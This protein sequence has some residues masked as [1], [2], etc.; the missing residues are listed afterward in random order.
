MPFILL[1]LIKLSVSLA[2]VFLFYYFI[3][4]KLTFYN[5]N[6]WYLLA[7]TVL[8][9]FIPF[10]NISPVLE[11]N[12]WANSDVVNWMP[13]IGTGGREVVQQVNL[14]SPWNILLIV[15]VSGMLIM[16]IR[17][18]IQLFSFRRMLRNAARIS[19][20]G[21]SL[22][23]VDANIIPFSF[24]NSIFINRHLHTET[25]LQ[26][27]ISHEF[28]HVK[29]R[30]S[31]DII[32]AEVLCLLN[33]YN[34]FVWLIRKCIRQNLEFIADGKVLENGVDRKQYQYLL[35]KVIGNNQFSIASKF[36]FS[37]LKKRIA[38]MN[39]IRSAK[40]NL[41]RF[42]FVLPLA[43]VLLLAFRN[44]YDKA[45]Q[46]APAV[47]ETVLQDTT[48]AGKKGVPKL[49][50][51]I[52]SISV[53]YG[54]ETVSADPKKQKL[55]E[56]VAVKR[57]DGEKEVYD[58]NSM[59][60]RKA[61]EKKYGVKLEDLVPPPPPT[62]PIPPAASDLSIAVIPDTPPTPTEAGITP[63]P[64]IPP[65]P[66]VQVKL[67]ES[68]KK[69][70]INNKKATVW[71]K[72]GQ[73]EDYDLNNPEQKAKFEIKYGEFVAPPPPPPAKT[74]LDREEPVAAGTTMAGSN[75]RTAIRYSDRSIGVT[76]ASPRAS[77]GPG[78]AT[79]PVATTIPDASAGPGAA[80]GT[81]TT[82]SPGAAAGPGEFVISDAYS[83]IS[84]K[85]NKQLWLESPSISITESKKLVVMDGKELPASAE[86]RKLNGTFKLLTLTKEEA[87]KKYGEKGKNGA[88]EIT[89]VK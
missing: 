3:L 39:K 27:I 75:D 36:N 83:V 2:V 16:L 67:P 82:T 26:E 78:R 48:P 57:T 29:Q 44:K 52:E 50:A 8:S 81:G 62:P 13:V 35:L 5:N 47:R 56:L 60:N 37:S 64:P 30:H 84:D 71:L 46:Q 68:V 28:V 51:G 32:W 76:A 86:S 40:I 85:D 70:S 15:V 43:V 10:I 45:T 65:T 22:Y 4:R 63:E 80:R 74:I 1:Y 24:G 59:E 19:S 53:L 89:T 21:M 6:R 18:L 33:W 14:L 66:P 42:L 72:N 11:K 55:Q 61:F 79:D 41:L 20:D 38:M 69:I 58:L 7:Y 31:L 17:L 23:Q 9:F 12:E 73:K 49:P 54:I 34:P 88:I 77:S 87:V 25:E